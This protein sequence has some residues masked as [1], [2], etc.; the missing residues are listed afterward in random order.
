MSGYAKRV[1]I[2]RYVCVYV[3]VYVCMYVCMCVCMYVC[4]LQVHVWLR[5]ARADREVWILME[6]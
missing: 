6:Q 4:M 3:C 5:Q 2:E 1:L